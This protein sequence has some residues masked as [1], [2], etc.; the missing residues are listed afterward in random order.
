MKS[1]SKPDWWKTGTSATTGDDDCS[2]SCSQVSDLNNASLA[3]KAACVAFSALMGNRYM[4]SC[5]SAITSCSVYTMEGDYNSR[6]AWESCK[7]KSALRLKPS[8]RL[9]GYSSRPGGVNRLPC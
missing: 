5:V 7:T 8:T 1:F 4:Y 3:A 2:D 9:R 6:T